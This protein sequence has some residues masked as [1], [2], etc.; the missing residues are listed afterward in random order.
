MNY[1]YCYTNKINRK[2]YV[3]QTNNIERRK[4][5]HISAAFN[6]NSKD[7]KYLFHKKLREYGPDNFIFSILEE[8]TKEK[9]NEAEQFWIK[10][11]H[12]Y[13]QE[14]G[15][16]LTLGGD[17]PYSVSLYDSDIENIKQD[18]RNGMPYQEIHNKYKISIPHIS[19]INHGTYYYD[20]D[21]QYPLYKYYKNT[22]EVNFIKELL[23]N[24][25]IPMTELAKQTGMAYSTIKKINSGALHYDKDEMYPIRSKNSGMQRAEQ[26]Q[27]MLLDGSSNQQIIAETGVSEPTIR[28]INKG[29]TYYNSQLTY[30]LRSL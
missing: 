12:S 18:I 17:Q 19:A 20:P 3:G 4:H 29:E 27:Q 25:S 5:E 10:E 21:E 6:P 1:I 26:V 7:Y 23:K 30:P 14:N 2:K 13:V 22:D 24:T 28:R 8:T 15:Y 16:N 11:L 9:V